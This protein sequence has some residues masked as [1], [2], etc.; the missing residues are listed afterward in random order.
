MRVFL[1]H[2]GHDR[3]LASLAAQIIEAAVESC[4]ISA[5][6][7][8]APISNLAGDEWERQ[9]AENVRSCDVVVVLWTPSGRKSFGL[10][11]EVGA[12][13]ILG[14]PLLT[15]MRDCDH[16]DLPEVVL[17]SRQAVGWAGLRAEMARFARK[18]SE[19]SLG[20]PSSGAIQGLVG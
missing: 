2:A 6:V 5:Q 7:Y 10:A 14:K 4:G 9:M 8:R 12:A 20:A 16:N 19:A 13:W 3:D 1:S 15:V 11:V 18:W 17:K